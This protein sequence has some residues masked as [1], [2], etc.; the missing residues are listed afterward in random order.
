MLLLQSTASGT[1]VLGKS[2]VYLLFILYLP[3]N[4]MSGKHIHSALFYIYLSHTF[5]TIF[6][7]AVYFHSIFAYIM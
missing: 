5:I 7:N 4:I 3:S 2:V 1:N 6:H